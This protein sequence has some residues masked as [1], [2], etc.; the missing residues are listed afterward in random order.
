MND[1]Q[2]PKGGD[3]RRLGSGR[4][5]VVNAEGLVV[6]RYDPWMYYIGIEIRIEPRD[7]RDYL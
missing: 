4:D 1:K 6:G 5:Y 2:V 7:P 3:I